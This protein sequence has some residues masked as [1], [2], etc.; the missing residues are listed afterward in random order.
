M[1]GTDTLPAWCGYEG[2]VYGRIRYYEGVRYG[3]TTETVP[4]LLMRVIRK[5]TVPCLPSVT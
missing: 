3:E 2:V 5:R 4:G 1:E